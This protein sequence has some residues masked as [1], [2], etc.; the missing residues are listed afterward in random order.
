MH[1]EQGL[2]CK[3]AERQPH[4]PPPNKVHPTRE[5]KVRQCKISQGE[6]EELLRVREGRKEGRTS[7]EGA[8]AGARAERGR[9]H[10]SWTEGQVCRKGHRPSRAW[11]GP[12]HPRTRAEGWKWGTSMMLCQYPQ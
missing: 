1:S 6:T 11:G 7:E 2:D 3:V 8:G 12:D 5:A 9:R 4:H 10:W